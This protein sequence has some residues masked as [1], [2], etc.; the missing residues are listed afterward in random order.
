MRFYLAR[1][2]G[3]KVAAE[4]SMRTVYTHGAKV[5]LSILSMIRGYHERGQFGLR[6]F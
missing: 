2:V 4:T 1:L 3:A 6:T 5:S